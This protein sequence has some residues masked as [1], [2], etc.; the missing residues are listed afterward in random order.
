MFTPSL[1]GIG[2]RVHLTSPQVDLSTHIADVVN[3]VLYEDLRDIT[4]VGFSYGGFV[5]SGS[6]EHIGDRVRHLVF[7]DA[8]VPD[9]GDTLF[10]LVGRSTTETIGV[11]DDWLVQPPSRQF[12]DESEASFMNARRT[13]HPLR[14]FTEAVHLTRPLEDEPF[15]R[16][17]IRATADDAGA[18]GTS[19]FERAA[20][21]ARTSEAWQYCEVATNHMVASNRP[22]ELAALLLSMA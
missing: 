22:S 7:L 8:F 1:T 18:P 11:G 17:Y 5:V 13:P 21:R 15:Q 9:D 4:L 3:H 16:T 12:D 2:E 19:A 20:A 6:I 10:G 14:C